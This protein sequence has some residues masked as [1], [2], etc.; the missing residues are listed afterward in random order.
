MTS[1]VNWLIL[2]AIIVGVVALI[3]RRA[4]KD[5][6]T[7]IRAQFGKAGTKA[8]NADPMAVWQQELND[9][10]EQ[11]AQHQ[12]GL[13]EAAG[14]VRRYRR[15][16]ETGQQEKIRLE[17]LIGIAQANNDPNGTAAGY[18]LELADVED[19][20]EKDQEKLIKAQKAF[21]DETSNLALFKKQ[22]DNAKQRAREKGRELAQS[23]RSK[24]LSEFAANFD[25]NSF[26]NNISEAEDEVDRQ[27]DDNLGAGDV[28][29]AMNSEKFKR[30]K[31]EELVRQQKA[32]D[33][34]ARF[35][36]KPEA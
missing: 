30:L 2:G 18:A 15:E 20:L 23:E 35:S 3:N 29:R 25:P 17:N 1:I 5:F 6:F 13:R 32:K 16:V 10:S 8:K 33:I 4:I 31:D 24:K 36:K 14:D 7:A 22:I 28:D 26:L 9:A 12:T 27:I 34:L 19:R 11:I 21:D